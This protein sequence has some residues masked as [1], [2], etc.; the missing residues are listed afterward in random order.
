MS[1]HERHDVSA[2]PIHADEIERR[3]HRRLGRELDL[4]SLQEAIGPGLVLWHPRGALVRKRMEDWWRDAHLA[5][6]YQF[7]ASPH[8]GRGELWER[9]GHL[10]QYRDSM[11]P[12]MHLEAR[13]VFLKPMNCPFHLQ[14]VKAR[15]RRREE[16]PLRLCELGQVYRHEA[17]GALHGLFR[18]RGFV[19]D[20]AHLVCAPE[21]AEAEVAGVLAFAL[22]LL[23]AFGFHDARVVLSSRPARFVG[24][25]AD[26]DAA[27]RALASAAERLGVAL[28]LQ[29]GA[30]AFY[31]PKLDVL[32][33]DAVGREWQCSS[34]QFDFNLPR[35]FELSFDDAGVARQPVVIHRALFGSL[36]RFF[37]ILL[38][39]CAG[40][41]PAWLAP[42]QVRVLPVDEASGPYAREVLAR[43]EDVGVSASL[44]MGG[45]L[46]PR[47]R[48]ADLEHVPLLAIVGARER[49]GRS[50]SLRGRASASLGD[51][52]VD[53]LAAKV[54]PLLQRP[55]V[56]RRP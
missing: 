56:R 1:S 28:S 17:S 50:V 46:G 29:P 42:E 14:I 49:A 19:Q 55:P 45:N 51:V 34:V 3:D 38:E 53:A 30:G 32:I 2:S 4:F 40:A 43:L 16:L 13:E 36:E 21:Q 48:A 6:N 7:V 23:A 33:R 47:G 9:S 37:A 15:R 8:V 41:F 20:D 5:R 44:S 31:G 54:A 35:A 18:A 12:P 26:W 39:H 11:F 22:E 24:E 52:P 10:A 25:V 27:E